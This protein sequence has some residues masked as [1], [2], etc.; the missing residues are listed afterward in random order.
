MKIE[1]YDKHGFPVERIKGRWFQNLL[2][3]IIHTRKVKNVQTR[4][5]HR[6]DG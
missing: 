5:Y 1:F 2:R 6:P 4:R 3:L